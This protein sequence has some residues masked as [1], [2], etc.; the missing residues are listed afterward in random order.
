M[1]RVIVTTDHDSP[2]DAVATLDELVQPTNLSDDRH[3]AALI[4]RLGWAISD[5][6]DAE[7]SPVSAV[8]SR[9]P[10]ARARGAR[11]L[12]KQVAV[13]LPRRAA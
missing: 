2:K 4:E 3:A 5:A 10:R 13:L 12:V 6:A 9:R 8:R 7:A 11:P 1:P